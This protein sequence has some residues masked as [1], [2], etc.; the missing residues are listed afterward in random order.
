MRTAVVATG[1]AAIAIGLGAQPA[2]AAGK[3][4][5]PAVQYQDKPKGNQRCDNCALWQAD[6]HCKL[7]ADPIAPS[8]WCVL[9]KAKS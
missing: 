7:V 1:G 5:H 9:Y 3:M 8:G 2:A 4:P 6:V